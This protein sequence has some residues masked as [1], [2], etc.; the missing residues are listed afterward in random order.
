LTLEL[1]ANVDILAEVGRARAGRRPVL[2]GFALETDSDEQTVASARVKREEK[3]VDLM[4]ANRADDVLGRDDNRATLIS[5]IGAEVLGEL[6]KLELSDR[7]ID[8]I[9]RRFEEGSA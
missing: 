4:V 8:W 6:P 9:A 7:I 1:K 2:V 5:S 3:R